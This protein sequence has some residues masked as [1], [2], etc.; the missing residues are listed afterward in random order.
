MSNPGS[1]HFPDDYLTALE[2]FASQAQLPSVSAP[3]EGPL[4][5]GGE[6]RG[7]GQPDLHPLPF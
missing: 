2:Q 5:V 1:T 3:Q 7:V 4:W 6:W